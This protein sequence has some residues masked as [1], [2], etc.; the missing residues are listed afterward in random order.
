MGGNFTE[1]NFLGG[2]GGGGAIFLKCNF[3]GTIFQEGI[4]PLGGNFPGAFFL[5]RESKI[6]ISLFQ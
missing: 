2:G 5:G 3:L 4:F 6:K 1:S